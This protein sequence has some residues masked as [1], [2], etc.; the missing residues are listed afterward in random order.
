[1]SKLRW[2]AGIVAVAGTGLLL[3]G[4]ASAA[5]PEDSCLIKVSCNVELS[6]ELSTGAGIG[7]GGL[8][9]DTD[10]VYDSAI[11]TAT[12]DS[13]KNTIE[14]YSVKVE[15]AGGAWTIVQSDDPGSEEVTFGLVFR[16]TSSVAPAETD[17]DLNED[18]LTTSYDACTTS[19]YAVNGDEDTEK[20][21]NVNPIVGADR[22]MWF[23]VRTP[24]ATSSQDEFTARVYVQANL[25]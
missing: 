20:G 19:K 16:S 23:L 10:T 18:Y 21:I 7:F 13:G 15:K 4:Q 11:S 14:T 8:N 9:P 1:M 2:L 5:T 24:K 22:R 6:V 3:V 25:P 12:N 17:F